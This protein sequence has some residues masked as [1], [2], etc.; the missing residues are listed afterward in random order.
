MLLSDLNFTQSQVRVAVLSKLSSSSERSSPILA[1]VKNATVQ[2]VQTVWVVVLDHPDRLSLWP[3]CFRRC[4]VMALLVF[5][6]GSGED[7][8]MLPAP[9]SAA[10]MMS[11]LNS[12]FPRPLMR[13]R[14][15]IAER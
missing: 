11:S 14:A 3:R 1:E 6:G 4:K 15:A 12:K 10:D 2:A 7:I 9:F 5:V 8:R 13:C